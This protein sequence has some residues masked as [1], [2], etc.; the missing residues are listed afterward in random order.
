MIEPVVLGSRNVAIDG[1]EKR[2][3]DWFIA[4]E[5]LSTV[6]YYLFLAFV[7]NPVI[8]LKHLFLCLKTLSKLKADVSI[9]DAEES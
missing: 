5:Y 3:F 8:T 7:G 9:E 4:E 6:V 1:L 2:L